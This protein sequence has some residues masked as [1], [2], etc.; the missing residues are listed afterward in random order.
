MITQAKKAE[1]EAQDLPSAEKAILLAYTAY[2][3]APSNSKHL[4]EAK[5]IYIQ[6]LKKNAYMQK[7]DQIRNYYLSVAHE[8]ELH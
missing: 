3:A 6:A 4:T 5:S 2:K 1:L 7:S 8:L